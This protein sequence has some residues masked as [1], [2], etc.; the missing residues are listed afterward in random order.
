[1]SSSQSPNRLWNQ[2]RTAICQRAAVA[3]VPFRQLRYAH[4]GLKQFRSPSQLLTRQLYCSGGEADDDRVLRLLVEATRDRSTAHGE[5]ARDLVWLCALPM[6]TELYE[7]R[8]LD[9]TGAEQAASDIALAFTE[10]IAA[11]LLVRDRAVME[12]LL[13]QTREELQRVRR[14]ERRWS[15]HIQANETDV[16]E[17][18]EARNVDPQR[19]LAP[20]RAELQRAV[21]VADGALYF[22]HFVVGYSV[23]ELA[24]E[25]D[26]HPSTIRRRLARVRKR[27][28]DSECSENS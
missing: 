21:G 19:E 2:I 16:R 24:R 20:I 11:P 22:D 15:R 5:L 14:A 27:L 9:C 18:I 1:M 12:T 3:K 17:E 13:E 25:N 28:V 4:P 8:R 6:L 7:Q 26:A 10:A 23:S